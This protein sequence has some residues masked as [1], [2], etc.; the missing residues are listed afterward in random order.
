MDYRI[1]KY[2]QSTLLDWYKS[3]LLKRWRTLDYFLKRVQFNILLLYAI[4]F[5]GKTRYSLV[6]RLK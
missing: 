3:G 4:D 2:T 5:V 1:P 6:F